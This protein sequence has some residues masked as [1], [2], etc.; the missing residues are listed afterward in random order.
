MMTMKKF[1][2]RQS[3]FLKLNSAHVISLSHLKFAQH[4]FEHDAVDFRIMIEDV[5]K[6]L[7]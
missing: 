3:D 4:F 7:A 6:V 5:D 2:Q 1:M